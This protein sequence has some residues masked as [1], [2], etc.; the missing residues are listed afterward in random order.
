M[1]P[2][3][4][5]T[6]WL[7]RQ[8]RQESGKKVQK[9]RWSTWEGKERRTNEEKGRRREAGKAGLEGRTQKMRERRLED[10]RGGAA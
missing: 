10:R 6:V 7:E 9:G 5:S 1:H 3:C 2:V 4:P 8:G